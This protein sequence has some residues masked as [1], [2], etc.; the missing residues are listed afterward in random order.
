VREGIRSFAVVTVQEMIRQF[1]AALGAHY[2]PGEMGEV[3]ARCLQSVT[4]MTRTGLTVGGSID[5]EPVQRDRLLAM[6]DRLAANEPLQ[7]VLGEAT[8]LGLTLEVTPS[9]LIP[10]PETEELVELLLQ[11]VPAAAAGMNILDIGTGS[12]CI[13]LAIQQALRSAGVMALEKSAAALDVARRNAAALGLD[14]QFVEGDILGETGIP[15]GMPFHVIVSNPPYIAAKDRDTVDPRVL[16]Y[17]PASALFAGEDD[18][19]YY[20]AIAG[21]ASRRLVPGGRL[22]L[23]AGPYSARRVADLLSDSGFLRAAVRKDLS[24]NDRIVTAEKF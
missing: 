12:G 10:R 20:R 16:R 22:Y 5:L 6:L 8:F 18:L 1:R 11:E 21:F 15:A 24:G 4:G 3:S 23:E 2:S 9:V 19:V 13:A 17:E 7:Y 14:V